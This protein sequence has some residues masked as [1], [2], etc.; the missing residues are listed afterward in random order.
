MSMHTTVIPDTPMN[1][2]FARG[3]E[4]RTG[5]RLNGMLVSADNVLWHRVR[6]CCG[7]TPEAVLAAAQFKTWEEATA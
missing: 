1:R 2:V 5:H 6:L 4:N 3:H 7:E